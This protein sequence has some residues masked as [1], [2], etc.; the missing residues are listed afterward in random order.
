M[1]I[2]VLQAI[3]CSL[4]GVEPVGKNWNPEIKEL[5]FTTFQDKEL[6][7]KVIEQNRNDLRDQNSSSLRTTT[8]E[9]LKNMVLQYPADNASESSLSFL[10]RL[11]QFLST[12]KEQA[13]VIVAMTHLAKMQVRNLDEIKNEKGIC[14]LVNLLQG[15][16]K[17]LKS[18]TL[19]VIFV[20]KFSN[21]QRISGRPQS[22]NLMLSSGLAVTVE[23]LLAST[24]NRSALYEIANNLKFS[25]ASLQNLYCL[26]NGAAFCDGNTDIVDVPEDG[27]NQSTMDHKRLSVLIL[28]I[29]VCK[30]VV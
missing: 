6:Q 25:L 30:L 3:C 4:F 8:V 2:L 5:V 26:Q 15:F 16:V 27:K 18:K 17:K 11:L 22:L 19:S 23:R 29:P 14:V 24:S 28:N 1:I 7:V 10:C 20:Q 13:D 12:P 21:P 9:E